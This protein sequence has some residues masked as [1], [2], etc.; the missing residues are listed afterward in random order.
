MNIC[1]MRTYS[2]Y[3]I[4]VYKKHNDFD[5]HNIFFVIMLNMNLLLFI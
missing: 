3:I 2:T 4:E 1:L 5:K